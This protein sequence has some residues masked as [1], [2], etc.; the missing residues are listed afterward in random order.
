VKGTVELPQRNPYRNAWLTVRA[1]GG[2]KI[3]SVTVNGKPWSDVDAARSRIRLPKSKTPI[4][5][6][7][8]IR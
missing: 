2:G 6:L 1:P 7:V 8:K 4:E 3:A 5:V